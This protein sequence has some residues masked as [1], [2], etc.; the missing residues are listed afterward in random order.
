MSAIKVVDLSKNFGSFQAVRY[1]DLEIK[2]GELFG[3]LGPNGA[4]KTTAIKMMTG[5]LEPNTGSIEVAGTDIWKKPL[6]AKRKMAAIPDVPIL[7]PKLTGREF[8]RFI[9]SVYEI[10]QQTF[11]M[12][13]EKYL[14]IF[15]LTDRADDLI[16][17]YSHGMRQKINLCAAF[18]HQPEV[19]FLDE[20]TVGLDPKGAKT[21]KS[22]L[23]THCDNGMTVFMSTHILEIAEQMCDRVGIINKGKIIAVG[24]MAELKHERTESSLE[25]LFLNLTGDS[26]MK[27][28]IEE[29]AGEDEKV[30]I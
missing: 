27:Y 22:L 8:L 29:L 1:I 14:H 16:E 13:S 26:D 7:Y 5:L 4:G 15:G 24:T 11:E 23:R 25:E 10:E 28:L 6:E 2:K 18:I 20:P 21:L 12:R 9:G 3:F 30:D 17:S 19:L